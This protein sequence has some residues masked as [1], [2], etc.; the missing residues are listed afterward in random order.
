VDLGQHHLCNIIYVRREQHVEKSE[1]NS[2]ASKADWKADWKANLTQAVTTGISL[3]DVVD[4]ESHA[5]QGPGDHLEKIE[6]RKKR[7]R[8]NMKKQTRK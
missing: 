7:N 6:I 2:T 8:N 1:N 4:E 5:M 3:L